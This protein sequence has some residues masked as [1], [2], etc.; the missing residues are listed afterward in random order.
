MTTGMPMQDPVAAA[1]EHSRLIQEA[2]AAGADQVEAAAV[3][4][5]E[6]SEF[7]ATLP[8]AERS[9][10]L[11]AYLSARRDAGGTVLAAEPPPAPVA[12]PSAPQQAK[13]K[14]SSIGAALVWGFL[15]VIVFF[16]W[17]G[18][19]AVAPD[20][21]AS[22]PNAP[23]TA[24]AQ[25]A[26]AAAVARPAAPSLP[27]IP[28]PSDSR[29]SYYLVSRGE[30][31]GLPITLVRRDG[32]SGVTYAVRQYNCSRRVERYLGTGDTPEE[33]TQPRPGKFTSP[34]PGSIADHMLRFVCGP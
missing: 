31:D 18:H 15:A 9:A 8:P 29:A 27:K 23:S 24:P 5:R 28:V 7:A 22:S 3:A 2:V 20:S 4:D 32:S 30:I 19:S 14:K 33:A 10:W 13:A 6:R 26:P 1:R 25:A 34:V 21:G 12:Q 17:L 16:W 11:M